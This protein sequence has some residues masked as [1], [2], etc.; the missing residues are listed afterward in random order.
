MLGN[1]DPSPSARTV[2]AGVLLPF[3]VQEAETPRGAHG[4]AVPRAA[5]AGGTDCPV[6]L[7]READ[8]RVQ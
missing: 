5:A 3:L 8:V 6:R 2:V 1:R 7:L 4:I